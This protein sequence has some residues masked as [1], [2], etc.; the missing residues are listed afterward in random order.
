MNDQSQGKKRLPIL[1]VL[2]AGLLVA[3]IVQS[4]IILGMQKKQNR[5]EETPRHS[6]AVA[7]G[8][9]SPTTHTNALSLPTPFDWGVE[10]NPFGWNPDDWDPF[11]EMHS[12]QDRINQMFGGAFGRFHRSDEFSKRFGDY[13][14]A[15]DVNLEDKGDRYVVTVDL[16]G[17]DDARVDVKV[18]DQLL[19]ISGTVQ[20]ESSQE[21][22]G[23]MLRQERR[24]GSFRRS[25]TL[26]GPVRS[27]KMTTENKKG[28]LTITIPKART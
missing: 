9:R 15:P 14:F 22:K 17:T 7:A 18:E 12:M 4:V 3:V 20:S 16:P 23:T 8:N 10:K 26:P 24:S 21:D 28:V 25:L 5:S 2:V 6:A 13:T 11:K 1:P 19:T 27:D